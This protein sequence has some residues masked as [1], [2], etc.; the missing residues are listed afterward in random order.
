MSL[1][2]RKASPIALFSVSA[3]G[4]PCCSAG[5][6][7][8]DCA[9]A[10]TLPRSINAALATALLILRILLLLSLL[11]DSFWLLFFY[12]SLAA[13][14]PLHGKYSGFF[15]KAKRAGKRGPCFLSIGFRHSAALLVP[16]RLDRLEPRRLVR[17]QIPEEK[18]GRARHHE[19][20][21]HAEAGD[22]HTQI[23][24]EELLCQ[25]GDGDA[26]QNAQNCSASADQKR[27]GQELVHDLSAR[28]SNG[29]A[30]PDFPRALRHRHQHDGQRQRY[31]LRCGQNR[32]QC[33]HAVF[34]TRRMPALQ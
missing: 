19:R 7:P 5:G 24:R 1:L 14:L 23:S 16:Q 26:D 31:V 3:T 21:H 20:D 9:R 29:L 6:V 33:L 27:L 22:R 15:A 25:D 30:N 12:T 4:A 28:R 10:A 34:R 11:P 13:I 32:R 8:V 2:F 18:P 17:R